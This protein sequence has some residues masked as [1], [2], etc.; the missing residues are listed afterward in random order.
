MTFLLS[1]TISFF[2]F[3]LGLLLWTNFKCK[4]CFED[5]MNLCTSIH[6]LNGELIEELNEGAQLQKVL[7]DHQITLRATTLSLQEAILTNDTNGFSVHLTKL[8]TLQ[9]IP[10]KRQITSYFN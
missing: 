3:L 9:G 6:K 7:V 10:L 2:G 8:Y 4:E 1:F 5:L